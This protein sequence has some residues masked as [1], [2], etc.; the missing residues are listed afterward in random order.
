M[1][2]NKVLVMGRA[3]KPK[4]GRYCRVSWGRGL[5][6]FITEKWRTDPPKRWGLKIWG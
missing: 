1:R 3:G 5:R 2:N 4:V 6:F